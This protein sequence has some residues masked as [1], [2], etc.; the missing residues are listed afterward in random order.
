M[1]ERQFLKFY[2]QINITIRMSG[3]PDVRTEQSNPFDTVFPQRLPI[4]LKRLFDEV[5]VKNNLSLQ[6]KSPLMSAVRNRAFIA[7]AVYLRLNAKCEM[8]SF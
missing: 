5:L 7:V 3:S 2:K 8:V 1:I 6:L 4:V